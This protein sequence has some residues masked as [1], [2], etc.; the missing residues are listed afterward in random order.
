MGAS[1]RLPDSPPLRQ[2]TE[3]RLVCPIAGN[4]CPPLGVY[5]GMFD[6]SILLDVPAG[7]KT[8]ALFVS[9]SAQIAATG[10]LI[11]VPLLYHEAL[12][13]LKMSIPLP[14][15]LAPAPVVP[16]QTAAKP[17]T[18]SARPTILPR[19][20]RAPTMILPLIA[21]VPTGTGA[22]IEA[23]P[24]ATTEAPLASYTP[25]LV[26]I[27]RPPQPVA[28][29]AATVAT[30][31]RDPL[32]VGGDVQAARIITRVLPAYPAIAKQSRISGTVRLLCVIAKDGT[33]Q[34]L[35][36]VSGHPFLTRAALDAVRQWVY[37]PTLLNGEPIE[38]TA[39]IDVIFTL[40]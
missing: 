8:G 32:K 27:A 37:R 2:T 7:R 26:Q 13:Q 28:L 3:N 14:F 12:P 35:Q 19:V 20:Y 40:Q 10:V 18:E 39:P 34:K 5:A 22:Y 36:V 11:V 24:L 6:Q 30:P 38:V 29:P 16:Q 4:L 21:A 33:V 25:R 23:P 1:N 9:F 17:A 15:T 31:A